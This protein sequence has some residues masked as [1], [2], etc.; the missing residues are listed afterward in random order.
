MTQELNFE[1]LKNQIANTVLPRLRNSE[2]QH[3]A[4]I[5][6][7]PFL[8]MRIEYYLPMKMPVGKGKALG[9]IVITK[10]NVEA[11]EIEP[12]Y[13]HF[14][15]LANLTKLVDEIEN[16]ADVIGT[17]GPRDPDAPDM[18]VL[19]LKN[20]LH[21]G[22]AALLLKGSIQDMASRCEGDFFII[23]SS[24]HEVLC[25]RAEETEET[26]AYYRSMIRAVNRNE[27][28]PDD[29]L[30]DNLYI[31]RMDTETIEIVGGDPD[32]PNNSYKY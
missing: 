16:L 23:P 29:V 26:T 19:R 25:F 11:L 18:Y 30:S 7:K 4:E 6:T 31:Y 27:V 21:N 28:E 22:A 24:I 5:F 9:N 12:E 1:D 32:D 2:T 14:R 10:S 8:D 20:E 15:A 3:P 17:P 13:L